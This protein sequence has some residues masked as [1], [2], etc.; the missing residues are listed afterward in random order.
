MSSER[1]ARYIP[2]Q[3]AAE[4]LGVKPWDVVRL[5]EAGRVASVELVDADS[6]TEYRKEI[7]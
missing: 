6:L 5:I 4:I 1:A 7:R 3:D 2:I